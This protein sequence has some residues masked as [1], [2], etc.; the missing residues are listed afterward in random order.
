MFMDVPFFFPPP[1]KIIKT[2]LMYQED[3][4]QKTFLNNSNITVPLS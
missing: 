3:V 4:M 1:P 2:Y